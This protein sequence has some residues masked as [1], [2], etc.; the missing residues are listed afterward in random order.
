MLVGGYFGSWLAPDHLPA[1]TLDDAGLGRFG[2]AL[3]A[4]AIFL[5][6]AAAC[7]VSETARVMAYL[8]RESAGQCGPC[9]H[10][11]AA[12]ADALRRVAGGRGDGRDVERLARWATQVRGRGAC[13]HPDGA[14]RLLV[15]ALNVFA[16]ELDLHAV[17][18]RCS[19]PNQRPILPIPEP[20][21]EVSAA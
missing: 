2:A 1:I 18:G 16:G 4:G 14:V 20:P 12:I 3:G 15:S 13:H 10:G 8:A 9:T 5:L 11:L 21:T 17:E 7:G 19:A 6:P